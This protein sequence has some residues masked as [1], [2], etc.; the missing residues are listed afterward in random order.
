LDLFINLPSVD[1]YEDKMLGIFKFKGLIKGFQA[2]I[3]PK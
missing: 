2:T 3:F 1:W